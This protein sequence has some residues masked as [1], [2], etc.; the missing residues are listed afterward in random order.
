MVLVVVVDGMMMVHIQPSIRSFRP[1]TLFERK[2]NRNSLMETNEWMNEWMDRNGRG[3]TNERKKGNQCGGATRI[4]R[5]ICSVSL[6]LTHILATTI[7]SWSSTAVFSIARD[8]KLYSNR[9][10]VIGCKLILLSFIHPRIELL[11]LSFFPLIDTRL[12][13]FLWFA[14]SWNSNSP[15]IGITFKKGGGINAMNL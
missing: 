4:Y 2:C 12:I 8:H 15:A 11:S 5:Y 7:S 13:E 9:V 14:G 1:M 3:R 10:F 6:L